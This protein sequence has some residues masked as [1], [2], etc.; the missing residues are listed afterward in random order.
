M[1]TNY[2]ERY[3]NGEAIATGFVESAVNQIIAKRFVKKQQMHWT[4]RG[5]HL[6]LQVRVK[7]LNNELRES[8]VHWYPQFAIKN[9]NTIENDKWSEEMALDI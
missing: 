6:L 5:T 3:R 1:I 9:E 7:V 4:K 2:G 8:F